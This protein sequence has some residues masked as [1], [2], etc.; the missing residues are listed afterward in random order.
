MSSRAIV[1]LMSDAFLD[2][3][4]QRSATLSSGTCD[5]PILYRDA[6]QIGV[7][8]R[9]DLDRARDVVGRSSTVE[10]WPILGKAVAAIYAWEYRDSTVGSYG[11]VGLGVQCRKK[12]ARPSL[13]RLALDMGD[14]DDQ[15]I[16]VASLPVTTEAA[17]RAG[18]ELWGYPKYVA[19]IETTFVAGEASVRLGDELA[20]RV[21]AASGPRLPGQPI[22]TYTAR[23]GRLVRTRIDVDHRARW[24][25]GGGAHLE[26]RDEGPTARLARR[27]GLDRA[28]IV[29]SFRVDRF[30]ARLPLGRDVGPA[31]G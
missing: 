15:G 23:E 21:P 9:V 26:L 7:F 5:V 2:A 30:R 13:A 14:D 20:L 11:E 4:P 22:V 31:T 17:C 10:P 28:R 29:A 12:G 3:I 18:I 16:W 8:F 24:G 6:S 25:G 1:A 19:P 27:L